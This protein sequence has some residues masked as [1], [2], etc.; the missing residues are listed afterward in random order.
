[1][2]EYESEGCDWYFRFLWIELFVW[3]NPFRHSLLDRQY[4]D[5]E[6]DGIFAICTPW[7]MIYPFPRWLYR[8]IEK[9]G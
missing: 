3:K 5:W 8:L 1:M 2:F 9:Y 4:Y 6:A 7:F